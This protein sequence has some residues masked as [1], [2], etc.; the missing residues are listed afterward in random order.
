MDYVNPVHYSSS[1]PED[2]CFDGFLVLLF[3]AE[4]WDFGESFLRICGSRAEWN[5]AQFFCSNWG[6]SAR[7]LMNCTDE[8]LSD[9][10]R[11]ST[12]L[13]ESKELE[14]WISL[15]KI[16]WHYAESFFLH[17]RQRLVVNYRWKF[18]WY[19]K[20]RDQLRMAGRV[21]PHESQLFMAKIA[22]N[23]L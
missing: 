23:A 22:L 13:S 3:S 19:T 5:S 9:S 8:P 18:S 6:T 14:Y 10:S 11:K 21:D 16:S 2:F 17:F 20:I 7:V 4:D 1:F 12:I 15:S